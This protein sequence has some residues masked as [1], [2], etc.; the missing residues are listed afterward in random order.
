MG[1]SLTLIGWFYLADDDV[2]ALRNISE[3]IR[4]HYDRFAYCPGKDY[5]NGNYQGKYNQ[6][7]NDSDKL[8][9]DH[10]SHDRF[11]RNPYR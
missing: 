5:W 9:S 8:H 10:W 4:Y 3:G 11:G 6:A 2:K 7:Y 1:S